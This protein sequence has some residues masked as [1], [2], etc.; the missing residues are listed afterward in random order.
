MASLTETQPHNWLGMCDNDLDL[1]QKCKDKVKRD[2]EII[3]AAHRTANENP[4]SCDS[5]VRF[6]SK[7]FLK[8]KIMLRFSKMHSHACVCT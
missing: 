6:K 3:S 4:D 8:Y 2:A 7:E 5:Q 1:A